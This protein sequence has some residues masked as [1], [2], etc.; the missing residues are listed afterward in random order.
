MVAPYGPSETQSISHGPILEFTCD[1]ANPENSSP[2]HGIYGDSPF[3][4]WG[5]AL[6]HAG[7][8][9]W[10]LEGWEFNAKPGERFV[11]ATTAGTVD[12][13]RA[14]VGDEHALVLIDGPVRHTIPWDDIQNVSTTGSPVCA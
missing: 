6:I 14:N 8:H 2:S 10:D 9:P 1:L 5:N 7:D 13:G 12:G 4:R 11:V 3:A